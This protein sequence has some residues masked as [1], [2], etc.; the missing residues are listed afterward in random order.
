MAKKSQEDD[1]AALEEA[2]SKLDELHA[3]IVHLADEAELSPAAESEL[4]SARGNRLPLTL[5]EVG[6]A[7]AALPKGYEVA[8]DSRL[9]LSMSA[10]QAEALAFVLLRLVRDGDDDVTVELDGRALF[11]RASARD[12]ADALGERR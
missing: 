1:G 7:A 5:F 9:T 2:L 11:D 3:A 12:L 6:D 4:T 10:E 8:L